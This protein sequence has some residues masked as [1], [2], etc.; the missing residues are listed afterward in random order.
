MN[1]EMASRVPI[2]AVPGVDDAFYRLPSDVIQYILSNRPSFPADSRLVLK[3]SGDGREVGRKLNH[4][5][6]A[7]VPMGLDPEHHNEL[8]PSEMHAVGLAVGKESEELLLKVA[9][10]I[11]KDLRALQ[12]QGV[13]VKGVRLRVILVLTADWKFAAIAVGSPGPTSTAFCLWCPCTKDTHSWTANVAWSSG[14]HATTWQSSTLI[15]YDVILPDVL[16]WLVRLFDA[17]LK[18]LVKE[19]ALVDGKCHTC[20]RQCAKAQCVCQ[21]HVDALHAI[22]IEAARCGVTLEFWKTREG[23]A[24][25]SAAPQRSEHAGMLRWTSLQGG[26]K[27]KV[28]RGFN[29]ATVLP[30][31]RT[32]AVRAQ[33]DRIV[34]IN[35][36]LR[37]HDYATEAQIEA[38]ELD[39]RE[40][41]REWTRTSVGEVGQPGYVPGAPVSTRPA[42]Y[43]HAAAY[44]FGPALRKA[45]ELGAPLLYFSAEGI[46]KNNHMHGNDYFAKT[47]RRRST[48]RPPM[49]VYL[50][51]SPM[52]GLL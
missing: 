9:A 29:M 43:M 20:Y 36:V 47:Q 34:R 4:V 11:A 6:L 22:T 42:P 1:D 45:R 16:H 14:A 51:G 32:S 35:D 44:H 21:C 33:W 27:D 48:S 10:D 25:G 17:I 46:E 5:M 52:G 30:E 49:L 28:L 18:A 50:T 13:T 8:S 2:H 23:S 24:D 37:S 41:I 26:D 7:V 15:P 38:L 39:A 40:C 31:P 3:V 19:V 12:E